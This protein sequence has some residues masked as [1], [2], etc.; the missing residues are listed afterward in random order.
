MLPP[1]NLSLLLL[2]PSEKNTIIRF[3]GSDEQLSGVQTENAANG[4]RA[5]VEAGVT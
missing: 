5:D 2:N 1:L 3:H 4:K